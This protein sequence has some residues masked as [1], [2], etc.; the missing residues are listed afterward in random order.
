[1]FRIEEFLNDGENVFGLDVDFTLLHSREVFYWLPS[2][3][4]ESANETLLTK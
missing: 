4:K 1:M 2:A 3:I